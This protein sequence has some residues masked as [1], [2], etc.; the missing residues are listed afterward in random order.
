MDNFLQFYLVSHA[1]NCVGANYDTNQLINIHFSGDKIYVGSVIFYT[2][3]SSYHHQNFRHTN[4]TFSEIVVDKNLD[5]LKRHKVLDK[6]QGFVPPMNNL[7]DIIY[8][9]DLPRIIAKFKSSTRKQFNLAFRVKKSGSLD[10]IFVYGQFYMGNTHNGSSVISAFISPA[11]L[12]NFNEDELFIPSTEVLIK[13][14]CVDSSAE[15]GCKLEMTE[16][17]PPEIHS[18]VNEESSPRTNDRE[19]LSALDELFPLDGSDD[20]FKDMP[21]LEL[22]DFITRLNSDYH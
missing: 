1:G 2:D 8:P 17:A 18:G 6:L 3:K 19:I 14:E 10:C 15:S 4:A 22:P 21:Q 16:R 11:I 5:F 20:E 12:D 13:Q 9:L 7:L